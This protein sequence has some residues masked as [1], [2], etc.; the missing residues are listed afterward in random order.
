MSR[1]KGIL[2]AI[3]AT[4]AILKQDIQTVSI[5]NEALPVQTVT[6]DARE[7]TDATCPHCF[8][9]MAADVGSP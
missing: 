9:S 1:E 6:Q 2:L 5:P 3:A 8:G 7:P 4:E